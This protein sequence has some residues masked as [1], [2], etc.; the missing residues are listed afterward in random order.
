MKIEQ[1]RYVKVGK[2]GE[3]AGFT[4]IELLVVLVIIGIL[5]GY[6]GPK[7]MGHPEEA[8]RTKAAIQIQ[9]FETALN[10]YKLDNGTYPS[11]DQGLQALIAPPATGQLAAKWRD[12]GYLEK[13][14][15]PL[16]PWGNSFVYL[17]PGLN[18]DF[19]LSSYGADGEA[20]GEGNGKD[21]NSWEIE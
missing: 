16:D 9:A 8:K 6:I 21:V 18:G 2:K 10:M 5:A 7:I 12:G 1:D 11:T 14:K 20:G 19:D 13:N 3:E 15:L 17:S 4:L